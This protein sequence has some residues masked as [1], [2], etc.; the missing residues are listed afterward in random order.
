MKKLNADW[1]H[2]H[3]MPANATMEQRIEWHSE[4]VKHCACRPIPE[5][6]AEEMKKRGIPA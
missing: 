3:R 1:H 5:K 4:H 2:K 6:V